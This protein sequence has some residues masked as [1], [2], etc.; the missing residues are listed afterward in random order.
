MPNPSRI[1]LRASTLELLFFCHINSTRF[2]SGP[3]ERLESRKKKFRLAGPG[4]PIWLVK[5]PWKTALAD[6]PRQPGPSEP[7]VLLFHTSVCSRSR[8]SLG[9]CVEISIGCAVS[10]AM[11]RLVAIP[12][13]LL[14]AGLSLG[15]EPLG[16][17]GGWPRL[18][19][20]P[21]AV[22]RVS[23]LDGRWWFLD[24]DGNAFLSLGVNSV[25]LSPGDGRYRQAVFAKRG[26]RRDWAIASVQRLRAWGFNTLAASSDRQT[27]RLG[28]PYTVSLD[29]SSRFRREDPE[30]FPD[31]FSPSFARETQAVA[32]RAG[33]SLAADPWLLGYFSDDHLPWGDTPQDLFVQFLRLADQAP[34]RL[35]LLRFL[36]DRYLQ[37]EELNTA[38]NATYSAFEEVGRVPQVG[39]CIPRDDQ[40]D[41]L[42]LV[43]ERYFDTVR[44]AVR[45]VDEK[46]LLLGCR[47]AQLPP[48]PVLQAMAKHVNVVSLDGYGELPPAA[49]LRETYRLTQRP[50]LLT[51]FTFRARDAGLDESAGRGPLVESQ[52][53]RGA[54]YARYLQEALSLP[55]VIGCHW[56]AYTDATGEEGGNYGLVSLDDDPYSDFLVSVTAANQAA[57]THHAQGKLPKLPREAK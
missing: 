29:L 12:L 41:F 1:P 44:R 53:E 40:E 51:A 23:K 49:E 33:R 4:L 57:Y 19:S 27:W 14:C 46:H 47:F 32:R 6:H 37:I 11:R 17:Y 35:E 50:L 16:Q 36:E 42:R 38:W 18:R 43:A 5:A 28:T 2:P 13:L 39:A 21:A 3:A 34:G 24:P 15:Q 45:S 56:E 52:Q 31:V 26:G 7:D 55:M 48:A 22:F 25:N 54:R 8:R 20:T 9:L 30:S 10:S